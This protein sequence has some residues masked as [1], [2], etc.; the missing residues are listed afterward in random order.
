MCPH[1][2]AETSV[3]EGTVLYDRAIPVYILLWALHLAGEDMDITAVQLQNELSICEQSAILLL[4]RVH[5]VFA[6]S[7]KEN[8]FLYKCA[9]QAVHYV[10]LRKLTLG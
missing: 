7:H 4:R 8:F 1:C 6:Q 2:H 9:E 3:L 5:K 10:Q